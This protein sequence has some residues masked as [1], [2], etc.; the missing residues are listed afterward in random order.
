[1]QH[2]ASPGLIGLLIGDGRPLLSAVGFG[3]VVAGG[4]ALFIAGRGELLPHDIAYLGL[5]PQALC[6]LNECRIVHFMMHDRVSF[7]GSLIAIG[8]MY[9]WLVAGPIAS[10]QRWAWSVLAASGGIGFLSFLA[11]LGY[12]Y[13]DTW[14]GVATAALAPAFLGGLFL[15]DRRIAWLPE[16]PWTAC[17][18]QRELLRRG[19]L[20]A[21]AV[22]MFSGGATIT[23]V[24]MTA[25]FVPED[26]V[27]LGI[28]RAEMNAVN[29]RLVPLIAHD[30]A[31]FG[32]AVCCCGTILGGFALRTNWDR[33]ARQA[34][35]VAGIAG[36]ATAIGVH[37]WIG[38]TDAFHLSPAVLG[39]I[40]FAGGYW[41]MSLSP[42]GREE[43]LR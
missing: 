40:A 14:H 13:L 6:E 19:L 11:Y 38:Y 26:I 34:V 10:G 5:T 27:Y 3:L 20:L 9:L 37:P 29:P 42:L 31:G 7:G 8:V 33:A 12:G 36:F 41:R 2:R 35:A 22:G 24:G 4:F 25:V 1:M 18:T 32:G 28:G 23:F 17:F 39:A 30:R 43:L 16:K 21:T 15:T